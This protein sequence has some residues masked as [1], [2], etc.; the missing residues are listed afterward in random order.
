MV[1]RG[2]IEA[3]K[4]EIATVVLCMTR[5]ARSVSHSRMVAKR[6]AQARCKRF[7]TL[8]AALRIG[9]PLAQLMTRRALPDAL[10]FRVWRG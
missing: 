9:A 1:E 3:H 6:R 7:M 8:Q 5:S 2:G 4:N 10:Q